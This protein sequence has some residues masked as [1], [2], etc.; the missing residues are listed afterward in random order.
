MASTGGATLDDKVGEGEEC[1][2]GDGLRQDIEGGEGIGGEAAG[3][4]PGIFQGP[5]RFEVGSELAAMVGRRL[6]E[7][8]AD[9]RAGL[10]GRGRE[11]ADHGEGQLLLFE[12]GPQTLSRGLLLA[13]E[14]EDVVGDLEG[15]SE[16]TSEPF[17]SPN[18]RLR[19]PRVVSS[20]PT[21]HSRQ[22]GRLAS[23]DREIVLF[24]QV[25]VATVIDLEHLPFAD[26]V[27]GAAD[28]AAG[29]RRLEG[30]GEVKGMCEQIVTQQNRRLVAP[31]GV[32]RY[33][34]SAEPASSRTSSWTR[35]AV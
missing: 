21:G 35:V 4:F 19:A 2:L 14:V 8:S 29:Q 12:V 10:R 6:G 5:R 20:Q 13:P 32:D 18:R 25:E 1:F 31:L 11:Q 15:D 28:P 22:L 30:R 23:D 34:V 9:R 17:E 33:R 27:G 7:Q 24:S 3:V 26:H 16:V